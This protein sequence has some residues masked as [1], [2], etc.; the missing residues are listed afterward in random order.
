MVETTR[1][2][3]YRAW[4]E[5]SLRVA[6]PKEQSEKL[7]YDS[8]WETYVELS[9]NAYRNGHHDLAGMMLKAAL[10]EAKQLDNDSCSLGDLLVHLGRVYR[11]QKRYKKAEVFLKRAIET[12]ENANGKNDLSLCQP[13]DNLT[14]V[15]LLDMNRELAARTMKRHLEIMQKAFGATN[16]RLRPYLAQL[17]D[18]HRAMGQEDKAAQYETMLKKLG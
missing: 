7:V 17:A 2:Q 14:Q 8:V 13:L 10:K 4:R 11:E 1:S 9:D 15:Y 12:F 3:D 18:L 16:R 6:D 5:Q